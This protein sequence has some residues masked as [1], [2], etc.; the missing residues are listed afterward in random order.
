[1][2]LKQNVSNLF[3]QILGKPKYIKIRSYAYAMYYTLFP[4]NSSGYDES[5]YAESL[6]IKGKRYE[7]F[8]S[9]VISLYNPSSIVDVGC[10]AGGIALELQ[11]QGIPKVIGYD[12]SHDAVEVAKKRGLHQAFQ[13]DL[14]KTKSI[15]AQGDVCICLEVAEHLPDWHST[16]L[17]QILSAVA[18]ILIFTAARPGQGGHLHFNEREPEYWFKRFARFGMMYSEKDSTKMLES[19][20]NLYMGDYQENLMVFIRSVE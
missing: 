18:P 8:A 4:S 19:F 15:A 10:G 13:L 1:M 3:Q 17:C 14:T 11:K 2:M 7:T 5:F 6:R 12:Y 16:H 9:S 20:G